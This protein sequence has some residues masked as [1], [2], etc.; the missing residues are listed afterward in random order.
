MY[1]RVTNISRSFRVT[2]QMSYQEISQLPDSFYESDLDVSCDISAL[3]VIKGHDV[4]N[5]IADRVVKLRFDNYRVSYGY[6]MNIVATLLLKMKRICELRIHEKFFRIH[7]KSF[8]HGWKVFGR[9][10]KSLPST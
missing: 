10:M 4:L 9:A 6:D 8:D 1:N 7:G 2:R 5:K 3:D